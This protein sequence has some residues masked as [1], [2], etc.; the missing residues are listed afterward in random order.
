MPL[1]LRLT[2]ISQV[3]HPL[4]QAVDGP[5]AAISPEEML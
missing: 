4:G 3:I 5:Y 2:F 1:R